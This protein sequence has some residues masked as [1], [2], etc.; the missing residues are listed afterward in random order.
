[1]ISKEPCAIF[2]HHP[3]AG[4]ELAGMDSLWPGWLKMMRNLTA[5]ERVPLALRAQSE[6]LQT[7]LFRITVLVQAVRCIRRGD[8]KEAHRA[9]ALLS[10]NDQI[11]KRTLWFALLIKL[12]CHVGPARYLFFGSAEILIS[13]RNRYFRRKYRDHHEILDLL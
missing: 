7:K 13:F 9:A 2:V 11:K 3:S 12:L 6:V 1:V 5:D 4:N 10:Q 8:F